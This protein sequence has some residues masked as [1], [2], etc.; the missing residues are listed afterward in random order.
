MSTQEDQTIGRVCPSCFRLE[1]IFDLC[2][3]C[4]VDCVKCIC[5]EEFPTFLNFRDH[6]DSKKHSTKVHGEIRWK[7]LAD[8]RQVFICTLCKS[9]FKDHKNVSIHVNRV[10]STCKKYTCAHCL[11]DFQSKVCLRRHLQTHFQQPSYVCDLCQKSFLHFAHLQYHIISHLNQKSFKCT[12]CDKS[13]NTQFL[14]GR[15]LK[16]HSSEKLFKCDQCD[17]SF[18][19]HFTLK[20]HKLTHSGGNSFT[21]DTC[22]NSFKW[23][24][25]LQRHVLKHVLG[26]SFECSICKK[27]FARKSYLSQHKLSHSSAKL[28]MCH[29]GKTFKYL[30]GLSKH[31]AKHKLDNKEAL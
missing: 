27:A 1:P 10:H 14:L 11:L 30:P 21:C 24:S 6:L 13:F 31:R 26:K 5:E 19:F 20:R 22:Q 3:E 7:Q 9:L 4:D 16:Q 29:C 23:K 18:T 28:H 12:F 8:P 25:D 15:H 17:K 2:L